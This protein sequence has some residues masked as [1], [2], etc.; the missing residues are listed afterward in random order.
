MSVPVRELL[1]ENIGHYPTVDLTFDTIGPGKQPRHYFIEEFG[2]V[3]ALAVAEER[4]IQVEKI[5]GSEA[6][7]ILCNWTDVIWFD[8][9]GRK[10]E[11]STFYWHRAKAGEKAVAVLGEGELLV[12][13]ADGREIFEFQPGIDVVDFS[14]SGEDVFLHFAYQQQFSRG[15]AEHSFP[16]I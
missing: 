10:K 7:L 13:Y 16:P 4:D 11:R 5:P 3:V 2:I 15:T 8:P 14:L 12:F 9:G 1:F 6:F